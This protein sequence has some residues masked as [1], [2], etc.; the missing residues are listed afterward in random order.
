[1]STDTVLLPAVSNPADT[2]GSQHFSERRADVDEKI[3][4]VAQLLEEAECEGLILFDPA[5]FGWLTNGA[6]IRGILDR[7]EFPAVYCDGK[8]RWLL[9]SNVDT[10]RLF[11]EELNELGFQVKQWPWYWGRRD[12]LNCLCQKKN[13]ASDVPLE[14]SQLVDKQ[15][16]QL[17]LKLT[18]YE[19][20]CLQTVGLSVSHA[21]EATARTM[22]KGINEREIAAQVGHRLLHR[23]VQLVQ[24]SVAVDGRSRLY[25]QHGYTSMKMERFAVIRATGQKYGICATAARVVSFGEIESALRT[26]H[27]AATKVCA[28]YIASTWPDA[29]PKGVLSTGRHVYNIS[30]YEHEWQLTPQGHLTGRQAVERMILPS[31]EELFQTGQAVTW[32]SCV[33][34]SN[35]CDTFLITERG[36]KNVTP[37]EAWP[38]RKIRVQGAEFL[39]PDILQRD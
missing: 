1:M 6:T 10:Q 9:C 24:V 14:N 27:D 34:A 38:L 23:G 19:Q 12:M 29:V 11:D 4:K 8:Q 13:L 30:G 5:N 7:S 36:A 17:R 28:T 37:T 35:V 15:M 16:Q 32:Q 22:D 31:S 21:I 39:C 2:I 18:P 3:P 33:G 25:R 26:E 20:A